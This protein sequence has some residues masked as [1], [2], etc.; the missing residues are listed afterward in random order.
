MGICV[1]RAQRAPIANF[2]IVFGPRSL[3]YSP[4]GFEERWE[5]SLP[6]QKIA[7]R[8]INRALASSGA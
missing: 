1:R 5:H 4:K 2:D 7:R 3:R 8:H 6:T